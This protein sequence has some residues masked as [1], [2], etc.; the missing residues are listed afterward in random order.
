MPCL[1][2][3][4]WVLGIVSCAI[5]SFLNQFFTYRQNALS[6]SSVSA[7]I[8]VLPAGKLMA[9]YLPRKSIQIPATK[10]SFSLNPGPF[11]MK[12]HV[13]I[14]IFANSGSNT[15]YPVNIVTIVKAFYGRGINLIAAMMLSQSTQM[16]GYGWAGIFRRFLVDSPYM[17]WP[18]NL[19]QV[20]LFQALHD[21]EV[22]PKRGQTRLQFFFLVFISSFAY[23]IVPN[24]LFPSITAL[25]FVCW[26]WK[27]SVTAQITGSDRHGLGI[28]SFALDWSTVSSFLLSPLATPCFAIV[29]TMVGFFIVIYI[30]IPTAYWT[31]SYDARKFPIISSHVFASDGSRYNVTRVMNQSTFEFNLH[32]YDSYGKINLSIFFIYTCGLSFGTLTA[33]KSH[34]ALFYGRHLD[35]FN[36]VHTRL[37]KKNYEAVPQWWFHALLM[38]VIGLSILT[39]EGFGGQLLLPYWGVILAA[40]LAM[41]FTLPIGVITATTNQVSDRLTA[42]LCLRNE[43]LTC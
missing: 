2:F 33:T 26:I 6:I 8:L 20:S 16:L 31:N 14:T 12:E 28:G 38:I 39:C 41:L 21:V 37:I 9:A 30:L 40:L 35:K 32:G 7:Q 43:C 4:T 5:L 13:L 42:K 10:W 34:V 19:V 15:V 29:N 1:T 22:R 11:N 36:N 17:W 23:Y 27:D 24:Y 3:R 18:S 25:S